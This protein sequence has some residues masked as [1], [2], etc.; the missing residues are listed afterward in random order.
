MESEKTGEKGGIS[1]GGIQLIVVSSLEGSSHW[2]Q[3]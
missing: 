2:F 3:P 1:Q